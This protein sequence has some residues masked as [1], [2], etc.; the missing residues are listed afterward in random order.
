MFL[1]AA[2]ITRT[3]TTEET[4]IALTALFSLAHESNISNRWHSLHGE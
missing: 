3:V 2:E 1:R 4:R